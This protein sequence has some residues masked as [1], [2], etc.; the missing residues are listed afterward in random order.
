VTG[1]GYSA[2]LAE[3]RQGS[4]LTASAAL[5]GIGA[6]LL[7][8]AAMSFV[9]ANWSEIPRIFRVAMLL[10]G[11]WTAYGSAAYLYKRE[12]PDF[13]QAAV[14]TGSLVFGAAVMLVSQMYH[15]DSGNLPGFMFLWMSGAAAAGLLFRSSLTLGCALL[16]AGAWHIAEWDAMPHGV[17]WHF[18]P[19]WAVLTGLIA[20]NRSG[21]GLHVAAAVLAAWIV[22]IEFALPSNPYGIVAALGAAGAF[23]RQ[24][25]LWL[26]PPAVLRV[27][28]RF[29]PSPMPFLYASAACYRRTPIATRP[30]SR[31]LLRLR[32]ASA[33]PASC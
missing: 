31:R 3:Q 22:H 33:L 19:V 16:L 21:I 11:L 18:L 29:A 26:R 20:W 24:P 10:A 6:V 27:K 25:E 13:A 9:A 8:F 14:L 32:Q 4:K 12:L 17:H 28:S 2:I 7:G 1:E 23:S 30:P 15:I 5:A